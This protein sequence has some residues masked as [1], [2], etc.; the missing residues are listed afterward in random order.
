MSFKFNDSPKL[1]MTV[2]TFVQGFWFEQWVKIKAHPPPKCHRNKSLGKLDDV[3]H[4][5]RDGPVCVREPESE[6]DA[7]C[8]WR[9]T[10]HQLPS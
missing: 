10:A 3:C 4:C 1:S 9:P 2:G 5:L 6:L 7:D 8:S